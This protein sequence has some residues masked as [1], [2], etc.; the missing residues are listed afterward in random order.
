MS[1]KKDSVRLF[2]IA[3][4]QTLIDTLHQ[5]S[6]EKIDCSQTVCKGSLMKSRNK[7]KNKTKD[8]I[9]EEA[10]NFLEQYFSSTKRCNT[11]VHHKRVQEVLK[12]IS[13]TGTY[14]L[15]ETEL[16]YGAKLAWRNSPRCI[17]RIQW[18]KL[19]LFDARYAN[20]A[21][22]MFAAICNH[23]KYS[24][25]KGNIRST[26]TVFPPRREGMSDFRI[27]NSQ[28]LMY[29]GYKQQDGSVI[30][31]PANVEFTQ[32]CQNLGWTGEGGTWDVLPLVVSAN[33]EDP[34]YFKIPEDLIMRVP[35]VHPKY[36]RIKELGLQWFAVPIIS[37]ILLDVGG[38]EFPA[39]P[40]N[41]WFMESEIASRDLADTNR[42]N[43]LEDVAIK[44]GLE[45]VSMCTLWKD[46]ALVELNYAVLY[47]YQNANVTIVD[48]HYASERFMKH[49]AN[50]QNLRGGCP[51]DWV[52]IV[53]PLSGSITPV[54][55]Q[56][57][58]NYKLKPSY[59]YQE[60]AWKTHVWGKN[61]GNGMLQSL[62]KK[63][64]FKTITSAVKFTSD[65][66]GK[67]LS[68][69][70]KATILYAT[71]T[72]KSE[73]YA[74]SL[75]SIFMHAFNAKMMCMSDYDITELEHETLLLIIVSTFGNGDPPENGEEFLNHLQ[76]LKT[77]IACDSGEDLKDDEQSQC[78]LDSEVG[79][80]S[81]VR[82][83]VFG[84]G[85][86]A[87]P[88]FSQFGKSLDNLLSELGGERIF[89]ITTGDELC[90]QEHCFRRWA[91]D[92]FEEACE[93]FCIGDDL[94]V[95]DATQSLKPSNLWL[96]EKVRLKSITQTKTDLLKAFSKGTNR[97]LV[98]CSV[99]DVVFLH[100][101]I[102]DRQT[103]L[104]KINND[105]SELSFYPGDHIGIYPINRKELVEGII[106][107]LNITDPH[108]V[109]QVESL[110]TVKSLL[111]AKEKWVKNE[112]FQPCSIYMALSKLLDIT[113][114]PSQHL[115]SLFAT[116]ATDEKDKAK[117]EML[118]KDTE[119]Y[120]DWKA[121]Y[122]PNILEVLELFP[123]VV[124]TPAFV[125]TQF[126][127]LQPRFYSIS[128]SEE[129]TP[130]EIHITVAVVKFRTQKGRGPLHYGV[131]SN[132]LATANS[133]D[134]LI[135]FIRSA[136]NFHLPVNK[137]VPI[138][139]VGPGTG[140][141]PFRSFWQQRSSDMEKSPNIA[142][143]FGK[144]ILFAGYRYPKLELHSNELKSMKDSG[145]LTD[146]YTAYSRI[147]NKP[148]CYVQDIIQQI[149]ATIYD[150]II[151]E[152]GHFYVCGD[153]I[154]ARDV[155]ETLIS[156]IQLHGSLSHQ[157]AEAAMIKIQKEKRYH[158]DI[159][160]VTLK[161]EEMT[162]KRR[163]EA[164]HRML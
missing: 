103:I 31:D 163:E 28:V 18:S 45:T 157:E 23:L 142:K 87:Y 59:E 78:I 39:C 116:L 46:R 93:V 64:L 159:F 76:S 83:A 29:A 129:Y 107:R 158:E 66:Y 2:N 98:F 95:T 32:I 128:S 137:S 115:L 154:M 74:K 5:H 67:A 139:M 88:K 102:E 42:Y 69:R 79:V 110:E 141:A 63:P 138:I 36:E 150:L 148:K 26:I 105:H 134:E 156:I 99:K 61:V 62:R 53:P 153:I 47:S 94:D 1:A 33:G 27:W 80:L 40:F 25:N 130:R 133:N 146:V 70:I 44:M 16:I 86:S 124:L 126:L 3:T 117:L 113:T 54:F 119:Q 48:H 17:G 41:G 100:E 52:W 123:S 75:T 35:I 151:K 147:P 30:G 140:I 106:K 8:D 68:R 112:K 6:H 84:L 60:P 21:E 90:G 120:E 104:A 49:L 96:P 9:I 127:P 13:Q 132:Y 101:E 10:K 65:L 38:I 97:K 160:G 34:V 37:S 162:K 89:K 11:E 152:M 12:E 24:T 125:L 50:E 77:T 85:S 14:E 58:L 15:K 81:N 135:C 131:C 108:T 20:S 144:M 122:Y 143:N 72:G 164:K 161:T 109:Y 92:V 57:M 22:D 118:F 111:G 136:P 145:A 55:H 4:G 114:P 19:Q 91:K 82:F 7:A 121:Y 155:R 73:Q 51:A 71:E 43:V 149:S 56:E